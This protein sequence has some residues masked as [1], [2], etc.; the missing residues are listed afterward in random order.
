MAGPQQCCTFFLDGHCFGAPVAK[1]QEI[2]PHLE[3]TPVP[4]A[5][6]VVRGLINLRGQIVP[7]ICLRRRL[8]MAE[9]GDGQAPVNVV[10]RTNDG[11]VSLLVDEVGDVIEVQEDALETPPATLQGPARDIVQGVCK[12]RDRLLLLLDIERVVNLEEPERKTHVAGR[13]R[14]SKIQE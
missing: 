10:V 3:M 11:P 2:V 6:A 12:L 8:G 7:A 1:V 13:G 4:L 5:P 14:S 9:R